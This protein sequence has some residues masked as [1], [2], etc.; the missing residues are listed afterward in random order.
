MKKAGSGLSDLFDTNDNLFSMKRLDGLLNT[1]SGT[2]GTIMGA[3]TQ[4]G[5]AIR[6]Q[7]P[8]E[9]TDKLFSGFGLFGKTPDEAWK[10]QEEKFKKE[11]ELKKPPSVAVEAVKKETEKVTASQ[12]TDK[13][14]QLA[15]SGVATSATTIAQEASNPIPVYLTTKDGKP[16]ELDPPK[17]SPST[18]PSVSAKIAKIDEEQK[19]GIITPEQA[20]AKK[21]E[22]LK[23]ISTFSDVK[24][25]MPPQLA[26]TDNT[27]LMAKLLNQEQANGKPASVSSGS[28]ERLT[29]IAQAKSQAQVED[30]KL[31]VN[32]QVSSGQGGE[33]RGAGASGSFES[34]EPPKGKAFLGWA[35]ENVKNEFIKRGYSPEQ[36][37]IFSKGAAAQ[38]VQEVGW[39]AGKKQVGQNNFFNIKETSKIKGDVE[40]KRA[41]DK[42]E[43]SNDVYAGWSTPE[44]GI[45]G[46]VDF[47]TKNPRYAKAGV[48][49]SNTP[50][51]YAQSLQKAGFATDPNYAKNITSIMNGKKLNESIS[52]YN[53]MTQQQQQTTAPQQVKPLPKDA[54]AVMM[55]GG[56]QVDISGFKSFGKEEKESFSNLNTEF[57]GRIAD[58][59]KRYKEATGNDLGLG[60][61]GKGSKDSLYRSVE[62]Q[63][64]LKEQYGANAATPGYSAHGIGLAAD[65]DTKATEWAAKTIDPKTGKSVLESLGLAR[66]A[67]DKKRGGA[68]KWHVTPSELGTGLGDNAKLLAIQSK[69]AGK[70]NGQ[71]TGDQ[72]LEQSGV[73]LNSIA[74]SVYSGDSKPSPITSGQGGEFRGAGA[75]GSFSSSPNAVSGSKDSV[76]IKGGKEQDNLNKLTNDKEFMTSLHQFSIDRGIDPNN[77]MAM[78]KYESGGY[79]T[80]VTN[81]LGYKGLFQIGKQVFAD[82]GVGDKLTKAGFSYDNFE[83]ESAARQLQAYQIYY[84]EWQKRTGSG[85]KI[86]S[87]GDMAALQLAPGVLK[88]SSGDMYKE[89]T[90]AYEANKALDIN[91]D[92]VINKEEYGQKMKDRYG[93]DASKLNESFA[94]FGLKPT[95]NSS[96]LAPIEE[97]KT[98]DQMRKELA[99]QMGNDPSKMNGLEVKNRSSDDETK[100]SEDTPYNPLESVMKASGMSEEAIKTMGEISYGNIPDNAAVG[101]ALNPI[102]AAMGSDA[103]A[104]LL[105]QQN[106]AGRK[107]TYIDQN[108]GR[109]QG[110]SNSRSSRNKLEASASLSSGQGERVSQLHGTPEDYSNL[111]NALIS[112]TVTGMT[113]SAIKIANKTDVPDEIKAMGKR[114]IENYQLANNPTV[115]STLSTLQS[116]G[117]NLANSPL[118]AVDSL[119]TSRSIV[120]TDVWR[121]F[122]CNWKSLSCSSKLVGCSKCNAGCFEWSFI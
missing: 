16:I 45:A 36:A 69:F 66:V 76:R 106:A 51:E 65:L 50:E 117:A 110:G 113:P 107:A 30:T 43:G 74:S 40:G 35:K 88:S 118:S 28:R 46:Y 42:A 120:I 119:R 96:K 55:K 8:T 27:G 18:I 52:S 67:P 32:P 115:S 79:K 21:T 33:F 25:I 3:G 72:V 48:F 89:G 71:L 111:R 37:E 85:N 78:M 97:K 23:K 7:I 12:E 4:V 26:A 81:S 90:K 44:K 63:K 6:E 60:A 73:K 15:A 29:A 10:E 17:Q 83:K 62:T 5:S 80:D 61:D 22:E 34:N 39:D 98:V 92:G 13:Q 86:D 20:A 87:L 112:N 64:K 47:L 59:A 31:P 116:A 103:M 114:A 53:G 11:Q 109:G 122:W 49:D 84:D 77:V 14:K 56:S 104:A 99:Q 91:K 82:K 38:L 57:A 54:K 24:A 2:T 108:Q 41:Y 19:A 102:P 1:M 93:N 94:K 70:G 68:E 95:D 105:H 9:W 121:C 58:L 75:S 101:R 100:V